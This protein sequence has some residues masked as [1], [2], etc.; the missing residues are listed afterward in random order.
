MKKSRFFSCVLILFLF[1]WTAF[2]QVLPDSVQLRAWSQFNENYQNKWA[3]RWDEQ[4]GTPASIYGAKSVPYSSLTDPEEI[5]RQFLKDHRVIFR[6]KSD[7]SDLSR[8]RSIE[9]RG[10]HVMD[11]QQFYNGIPV[12]GGEYSV[13]V[14]SDKAIQM[15]AGKYYAS[16]SCNTTPEITPVQAIE[17][18]LNVTGIQAKAI[19]ESDVKL[20]VAPK[21]GKFILAYRIWLNEWELVLDAAD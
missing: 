12:L 5:A 1:V 4:T 13:A 6:M 14:G 15:V 3:L 19:R 11:F 9:S 17:A 18:G 20:V 10:V 8:L 2:G 16:V 21:G 7:L